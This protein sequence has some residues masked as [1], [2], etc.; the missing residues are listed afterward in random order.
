MAEI[1]YDRGR[2]DWSA[3]LFQSLAQV[4]PAE[5]WKPVAGSGLGWSLYE[6]KK[7][8]D[9]A[10]AFATVAAASPLHEL[11]PEA[12]FMQGESLLKAKQLEA[13]QKQFAATFARYAPPEPVE[14]EDLR[15]PAS[16]GWRAGLQSARTLNQMEQI[17]DADKAYES[18]LNRFPNQAN[19]DRFLNEWAVMNANA[20]RYE[21]SDQ[22]FKRLLAYDSSSRYADSARLSLAE[23]ALQA[24][25]LA[26][27]REQLQLVI[28]NESADD[29]LR[30][31][32]LEH[33]IRNEIS[34]GNWNEVNRWGDEFRRMYPD[35]P[36]RFSADFYQ[37]E[38]LLN[39]DKAEE[40]EKLL[41]KVY[42]Q[43]NN[44]EV[45]EV[46]WFPRLWVLLAE[47]AVRQKQYNRV[48][49]LADEMEKIENAKPYLYQIREIVGR[50][51]KNQA[52]LA[53]A[54]AVFESV[55]KDEFGEKTQT[56]AKC[57]F[58]IGE[59][60]LLNKDYKQALEAY[61]KVYLLYKFPQWQA[62]ALYQA[63]QCDE[64][65]QNWDKALTS[66]E[67]LLRDFPSSEYAERA[68]KRI[69]EV[70]RK[71]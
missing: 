2:Y 48:M 24:G 70:K 11:A 64:A 33:L 38:A 67:D 35:D 15:G 42:E 26:E 13:A 43:R 16:F 32:A 63:G 29:L 54:I 37:A 66:Y 22:I 17:D 6:N 49:Q 47:T 51:L 71:L 8:E 59:T 60:L 62:P 41:L 4:E 52:K 36:F 18:V 3:E 19:F 7:Y 30:K 50:S 10:K 20:E 40:A 27:A 21:K 44:P 55:I 12:S 61:L 1:V 45:Q 57:Q 9:A 68:R 39:Q 58:L 28:K 56:A 25:Q 14:I 53:E 5:T 23:S 46:N 34:A 65:L 31:R 69:V